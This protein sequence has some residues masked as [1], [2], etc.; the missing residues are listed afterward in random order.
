MRL[1][2][3]KRGNIRGNKLDN[4]ANPNENNA[5]GFSNKESARFRPL[6]KTKD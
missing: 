4:T 2:L 1:L 5:F 6:Q 3:R